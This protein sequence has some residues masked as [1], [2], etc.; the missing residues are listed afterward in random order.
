MSSRMQGDPRAVQLACLA[1]LERFQRD[2]AEAYTQHLFGRARCEVMRVSGARMIGMG[3]RNHRALDRPPGI[4]IKIAAR[5]IQA[6]R[7]QL[8]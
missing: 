4:D 3:M 6:L 7:S 1:V 8:D 5:A 2:V